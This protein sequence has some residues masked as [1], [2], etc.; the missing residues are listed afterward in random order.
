MSKPRRLFDDAGNPWTSPGEKQ[1]AD[2]PVPRE[3]PA[4]NEPPKAVPPKEQEAKSTSKQPASVSEL[5]ERIKVSLEGKFSGVWVRGELHEISKA[6]SG[7]IYLTLRDAGAQ[8]KAVIWKTQASRIRFNLNDG[9][10]VVCQGDIS[11]YP[12]RGSYQLVIKT[13]EPVGE[14]ALQIAFKQLYAKLK[15]EGLFD[16]ARKK[17]VPKWPKTIALI[18]SPTGAAVRD[19]IQ[20]AVRRWPGVNVLIIPARVQGEG[21]AAEIVRAI[22]AAHR[23]RVPPD[24][25]VVGRGGGSLEDLWCFNEEVVV[26][27]IARS[28]IPTISAVGHEI[29][30]TLCDLAADVRALTPSEAAERVTPDIEEIRAALAQTRQMLVQLLRARARRARQTVDA[31]A[32]RRVLRR[33]YEQIAQR[34]QWLD[35]LHARATRAQK[36]RLE[37]ARQKIENAARQLET[38]SPLATLHRG[39]SITLVPGTNRPLKSA[40]DVS[41][42]QTIE[43]RLNEGILRGKVEEIEFDRKPT[44]PK[45][46]K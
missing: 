13:I 8:L 45:V 15:A 28:R 22:G 23:L 40:A 33:P 9:Q 20:I 18:T 6:A 14:G 19:F 21:S 25:L 24:V 1:P 5:T 12:L 46:K 30:V 11:L 16:V 27:A 41:I 34:S 37:K 3:T 26:R 4:K 7:H 39:Y 32:S 42:G 31:L 2:K 35:E 38:L 10:E 29:D 17:P 44:D 43:T 36:S